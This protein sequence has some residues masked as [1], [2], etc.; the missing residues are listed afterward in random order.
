MS[1]TGDYKGVTVIDPDP[2]GGG[3]LLLNNGL[4][5]LADRAGPVHEAA[6]DPLVTNDIV[7][8]AAIGK[9]FWTWSKWRNTATDEIFILADPT[10]GAAV[11]QSA[12]GV[13]AHTHVLADITDLDSVGDLV[14]TK[15][16]VPDADDDSGAGWVVGDHIQNTVTGIIYAAESVAA[17]AAIWKP[18]TSAANILETSGPTNLA[19]GA[20]AD[21]QALSR[22]GANVVGVDLGAFP[23]K[24]INDLQLAYFTATQVR[25]APGECRDSTD[26]RNIT[27]G[28]VLTAAITTLGAA[29]GLDTGLES[30][31]TWYAVHI[32][33]GD[34]PGVAS[35]LSLSATSPTLPATYTHFRHVGWVRNDA[36]ADFLE[37]LFYGAGRERWV[38]YQNVTRVNLRVLNNGSATAMTVVDLS[39]L[40]PTTSEKA[41][42]IGLALNSSDNRNWAVAHGD[43]T[44]ARADQPIRSAMNKDTG[45]FDTGGTPFEILVNASQEIAYGVSNANVDLDL[46]VLGYMLLI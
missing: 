28:S 25:I 21:G 3:G 1:T 14:F 15:V 8:T 31:A 30:S 33:D 40:V 12:S 5:E 34:V 37:F 23:P 2:T 10:A 35:L 11:W 22:S 44:L 45:G 29:N 38:E 18:I 26:A 43:S 19:M 46:F 6:S 32:I 7:D 42:I 39:T 27:S 13:A 16:G 41:R 24:Y 4:K 9:K 36:S 17:A 20:V